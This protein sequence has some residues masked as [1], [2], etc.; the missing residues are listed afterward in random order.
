MLE[1]RDLGFS[2]GGA[3]PVLD[4][5]SLS[6]AR[7]EIVGLSGRSGCGKSTLGRVLSGYLRP[8]H[9]AVRI[10]GGAPPAGRWPVQYV[11]QSPIFSV[12]PR[13]RIGRII[14]EAWEPD[15]GARDE[16]GVRR[17]WFD[18]YPH[19][20]SGGELQRVVLLRALAPA[21]RY[22]IA[23]EATVML[24]PI[25]QAAI[26]RALMRR[27]R[28]GLGILAISHSPALLDRVASRRIAL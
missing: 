27:S 21:T 22:L 15:E 2:Y 3:Q 26:W 11:H 19:E 13:W 4:G 14:E 24:D 17:D 20:V 28:D 5:V 23:D 12:D 6:I 1:A 7:G 16:F 25:T 10:D 18:R 9:G 8:E